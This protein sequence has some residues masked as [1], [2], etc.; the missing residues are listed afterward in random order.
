MLKSFTNASNAK[1]CPLGHSSYGGN[2]WSLSLYLPETHLVRTVDFWCPAKLLL[3]Q[4]P[5]REDMAALEVGSHS[6]MAT[7][8]FSQLLADSS[9]L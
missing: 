8:P 6:N 2:G 3:S 7:S 4:Q 1:Y 9:G 5:G